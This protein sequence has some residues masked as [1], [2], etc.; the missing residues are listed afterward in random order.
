MTLISMTYELNNDDIVAVR[1]A[2]P[3]AIQAKDSIKSEYGGL[4]I[5]TG[6]DFAEGLGLYLSMKCAQA[7]GFRKSNA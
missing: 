2:L 1:D 4:E 6:V 5:A 3:N 7:R